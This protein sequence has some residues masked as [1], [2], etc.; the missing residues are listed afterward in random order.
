MENMNN[1]KTTINEII[2]NSIRDIYYSLVSNQFIEDY[3]QKIYSYLIDEYDEEI[4]ENLEQEI[5]FRHNITQYERF[6]D[7][8][9]L[10]LVSNFYMNIN[11]KKNFNFK[12]GDEIDIYNLLDNKNY[13][14][15]QILKIFKEK[16]YE[17]FGQ[18]IIEEYEENIDVSIINEKRNILLLKEQKKLGKALSMNPMLLEYHTE[19]MKYKF[20]IKQY[21]IEDILNIYD[22]AYSE[23]INEL[24]GKGYD[25]DE[26]NM[27]LLGEYCDDEIVKEQN[28][29]F[30]DNYISIFESRYGK[31]SR[32][33]YG[34]MLGILYEGIIYEGKNGENTRVQQEFIKIIE[35][36]S[37]NYYKCKL[38]FDDYDM[39]K[40]IIHN[41]AF[42]NQDVDEFYLKEREDYMEK[43]GYSKV[44]SKY[45]NISKEMY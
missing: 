33:I 32:E 6:K 8:C 16:S 45:M 25:L 4:E 2:C 3:N 40:Y 12:I 9:I 38:M 14:Y 21:F 23:E 11:M 37:M 27:I 24:L 41:F 13:D 31:Y 34:I 17:E 29:N 22:K 20:P 42:L 39:C 10:Y 19:V 35:D 28:E 1:Y 26:A 18:Y 36:D 7:L 15:F 5:Y 30:C 44:L 43:N